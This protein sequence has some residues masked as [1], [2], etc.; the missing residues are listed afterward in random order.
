MIVTP[1]QM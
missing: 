1:R